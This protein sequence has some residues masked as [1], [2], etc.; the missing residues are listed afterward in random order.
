L[1]AP[2]TSGTVVVADPAAYA[3]TTCDTAHHDAVWVATLRS[4]ATTF[5]F[6]IFVRALAGQPTE[7]HLCF[8]ATDPRL[9][10]LAFDLHGVF[11][12]PVSGSS[13]WDGRFTPYDPETAAE[14]AGQQV[15][16]LV[17]VELPQR[18][19]LRV[20]Y[21]RRTHTYRV[22][23]AATQNGAG[24]RGYVRLF[25]SVGGGPF[26]TNREIGGIAKLTESGRFAYTGR[27]S[28]TRAVR[29]RAHFIANPILGRNCGKDI[30]GVPCANATTSGWEKDSNVATLRP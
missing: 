10:T 8:A 22:T 9:A 6:P 19:S 5:T 30:N 27:L 26:T 17:T 14:V 21:S 3:T 11:Q 13:L 16:S 29:F 7:L 2:F 18:V 25:R 23:G 4:S 28:T 24:A 1:A 12:G 15:S 20:A